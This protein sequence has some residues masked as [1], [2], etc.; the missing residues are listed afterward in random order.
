MLK[1][2]VWGSPDVSPGKPKESRTRLLGDF[3]WQ[4]LSL[5]PVL[6]RTWDRE[7]KISELLRVKMS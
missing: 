5:Q 3:T 6:P 4:K 7:K 2:V 1:L